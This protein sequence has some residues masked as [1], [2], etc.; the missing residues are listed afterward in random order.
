MSTKT[1]FKRIALVAVAALGMGVLSSA[2]SQAVPIGTT[3]T[4]GAAGATTQLTATTVSSDTTTGTFATVQS[5]MQSA[6]DSTS[7]TFVA[8][9]NPTT[10]I[11]RR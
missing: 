3:V 8:K 1:N 7:V 10:A 9:S 4:A 6:G 11:Y 5:L 2:P